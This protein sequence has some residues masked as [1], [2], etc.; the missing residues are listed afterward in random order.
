M[1]IKHYKIDRLNYCKF[2]NYNCE[3]VCPVYKIT[4]NKDFTPKNKAIKSLNSIKEWDFSDN[5]YFYACINCNNCTRYCPHENPIAEVLDY[6]KEKIIINENAT[7][8]I[9]KFEEEFYYK[10][11]NI[12]FSKKKD[13]LF[14]KN[15]PNFLTFYNIGFRDETITEIKTLLRKIDTQK[16]FVEDI[17]FIYL[18]NIVK[19]HLKKVK[20]PKFIYTPPKK[21]DYIK[22][23]L[24][25]L[26]ISIPDLYKLF[27][28]EF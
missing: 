19:K 21:E 1:N 13:V 16:V 7:N 23:K 20:I 2:C 11:E 25:G 24:S 3:T 12:K 18:L 14:I 6:A 9:N 8:K 27:M 4:K 22:I 15:L 28:E 5:V 26:N 17:A 10:L